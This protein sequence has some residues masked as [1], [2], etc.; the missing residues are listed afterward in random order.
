MTDED[1]AAGWYFP[2]PLAAD[3]DGLPS[4][5][6]WSIMPAM[7]VGAFEVRYIAE[8]L[9]TRTP[10]V[11]PQRQCLLKQDASMQSRKVG[12]EAYLPPSGRQ[13]RITVRV[14][15]PKG[16]TSFVQAL[17]TRG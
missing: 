15:G 12:S 9:C 4:G 7:T 6:D 3:A 14:T 1:T 10:A 16:S 17:V 11:D 5:V 13:F 2:T 8:R